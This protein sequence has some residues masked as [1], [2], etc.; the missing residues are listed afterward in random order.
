MFWA[1]IGD[2]DDWLKTVFKLLVANIICIVLKSA[3]LKVGRGIEL[4]GV[5]FE[6]SHVVVVAVIGHNSSNKEAA[7]GVDYY[8]LVY[9][10]GFVGKVPKFIVL[11]IHCIV[12]KSCKLMLI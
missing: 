8:F 12:L 2:D 11:N 4:Y 9:V 5:V 3:I 1:I 7:L 6:F 10:V